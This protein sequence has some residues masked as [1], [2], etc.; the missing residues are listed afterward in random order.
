M[1]SGKF[2]VYKLILSIY[3]ESV[4]PEL[5]YASDDSKDCAEQAYQAAHAFYG[6]HSEYSVNWGIIPV[7][8][9]WI[10]YNQLGPEIVIFYTC[11]RR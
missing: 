3:N 4:K 10:V 8:P 11:R 5:L 7:P 1:T 2:G 9:R 6:K